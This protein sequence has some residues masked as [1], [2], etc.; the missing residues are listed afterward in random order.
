MAKASYN[1][2]DNIQQKRIK[3]YRKLFSSPTGVNV[4]GDLIKRYNLTTPIEVT[5]LDPQ[6]LTYLA[7]TNAVIKDIL[8]MISKDP[9]VIRQ[10][11]VD[12][13]E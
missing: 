2:S 11:M 3:D 10:E 5:E 6:V 1:K 13:N 4:L 12:H 8:N 7:G 9:F